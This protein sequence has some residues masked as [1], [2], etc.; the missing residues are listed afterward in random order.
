MM[1][2]CANGSCLGDTWESLFWGCEGV[3][4]V[5]LFLSGVIQFWKAEVTGSFGGCFS[6]MYKWCHET[7]RNYLF[8]N[9]N[10]TKISKRC[11]FVLVTWPW[12]LPEEWPEACS[13]LTVVGAGTMHGLALTQLGIRQSDWRR[14]GIR[15]A[16][17]HIVVEYFISL[18]FIGGNLHS[19]QRDSELLRDFLWHGIGAKLQMFLWTCEEIHQLTNPSK[20]FT[21]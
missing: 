17:L 10:A 4:P 9:L 21:C 3:F 18:N 6:N 19:E 2:C 8:I 7:R 15:T 5:Q 1:T 13:S 14:A 12:Q 11:I 16:N 20:V